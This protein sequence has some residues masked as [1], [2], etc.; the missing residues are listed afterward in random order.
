LCDPGNL[1][2]QST[3]FGSW[4]TH[5]ADRGCKG[6]VGNERHRWGGPAPP[7]RPGRPMKWASEAGATASVRGSLIEGMRRACRAP[8]RQRTPAHIVRGTSRTRGRLGPRPT[9]RAQQ[10]GRLKPGPGAGR[11]AIMN[12]IRIPPPF[13]VRVPENAVACGS[14]LN[15]ACLG[16]WPSNPHSEI[17]NP[18]FLS[19]F[20]PFPSCEIFHNLNVSRIFAETLT[21]TGTFQKARAF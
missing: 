4:I 3:L 21:S 20:P 16:P 11:Y 8:A 5:H 18:Q 1:R 7:P 19:R 9:T 2:I 13:P 14:R 12:A 10:A 6:R 15:A 17:R